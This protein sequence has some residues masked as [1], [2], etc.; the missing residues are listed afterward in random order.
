MKTLTPSEIDQIDRALED[1]EA[2]L[3]AEE[4][5]ELLNEDNS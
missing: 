5:A 3:T 2:T 4:L 1:Y